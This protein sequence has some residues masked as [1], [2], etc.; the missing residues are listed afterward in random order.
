MII[1]TGCQHRLRCQWIWLQLLAGPWSLI[2]A[3]EKH[4]PFVLWRDQVNHFICNGS[5][6]RAHRGA[7][8][9]GY[10]HILFFMFQMHRLWRSCAGHSRP[11]PDHWHSLMSSGLDFSL[12]RIFFY[13]GKEGRSSKVIVKIALRILHGTGWKVAPRE[14]SH[15]MSVHTACCGHLLENLERYSFKVRWVFL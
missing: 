12:E 6:Q 10:C 4:N 14:G 7:G 9:W 1:P 8:E 13:H 15:L 11:Q 3:G 5:R 2:L